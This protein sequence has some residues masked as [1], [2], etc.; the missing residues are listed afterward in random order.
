MLGQREG[1]TNRLSIY[2]IKQ[3]YQRPEDI[4]ASSLAPITIDGVGHF[5]FEPSHPYQPDWVEGFFGASLGDNVRILSASARGVLLVPI[6]YEEG[7]RYFAISFGV[8]R[9]LLNEGVI[10]ERFGLKVVLNS[11]DESSLRSIDKTTLGSVPKHS[12]EQMSRDVAHSEF[13]IDIEQDLINSVT[14]KSKDD[15]LGKIITGKDAFASSIKADVTNVRDVLLHCLERY[16]SSDYRTHFDWI[17]QI[18]EIRDKQLGN[19]LNAVLVE[20]IKA[21]SLDKTWMAVPELVDWSDVKGFRYIRRQLADLHDD[22]SVGGLLIGFG[23]KPVTAELLK[24]SLVFMIS[25]SKDEV[26]HQWPAFRCLYAEISR[27][28]KLYVL[29]NGK[30]YEVAQAFTDQVQR[31]FE[32]MPEA[33]LGLPECT[34]TDEGAYNIAATGA[35]P[36]A[37]CMDGRLVSYGGGHSKIEFCDVYTADKKMIHVKRYGGS[38]VLSHLFAQGLVSGELFAGDA[39]FRKKLNDELPDSHRLTDAALRPNPQEYEIVYAVISE[40]P[41]PLDIPFFSKVNL[42]NARRRLRTFGYQ[43]SVQKVLRRSE[44]AAEG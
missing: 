23:E 12:R 30:W 19:D 21:G 3:E 13:G 43:V 10:E 7:N 2:L 15:L 20:Q 4:V 11:L 28:G 32:S 24:R 40:S 42:R 9:H 39:E 8:G 22:L 37:C 41:G 1:K 29:T 33:M 36:G 6:P 18:A 38:S 26:I 31:D 34:V 5:F 44:I 25:A 14:G 35:L 16:H 17:D 27:D